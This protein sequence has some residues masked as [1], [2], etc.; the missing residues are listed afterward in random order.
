MTSR[1]GDDAWTAYRHD[2][3]R[4]NITLPT[5]WDVD[6]QVPDC[7]L[8]C[9]E[10]PPA[11]G[12]PTYPPPSIVVTIDEL[13]DH[14]PF[15]DW[16]QRFRT[17]LLETYNRLRVIDVEDTRLGDAP[18]YRTLSHYLH[19]VGGVCTDQW[20]IPAPGRVYVITCSSGVLQYDYF[21][22]TFQ[23]VAAGFRLAVP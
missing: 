22:D 4:L 9:A 16:L 17:S 10:P 7:S 8:V 23:R 20:C 3:A 14:E 12:R 18:A 15:G 11:G 13:P 2:E 5:G 21:A 6:Q 1:L 19:R